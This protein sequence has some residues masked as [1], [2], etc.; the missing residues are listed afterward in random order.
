MLGC[1]DAG[2]IRVEG[3]H[4]PLLYDRDSIAARGRTWVITQ[5]VHVLLVERR[6]IGQLTIARRAFDQLVGE[7]LE[8]LAVGT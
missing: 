6:I 7:I 5:F 3:A 2:V 1:E 8:A 4:G